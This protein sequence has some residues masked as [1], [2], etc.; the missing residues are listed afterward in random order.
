MVTKRPRP[1]SDGGVAD[2]ILGAAVL[3]VALRHALKAEPPPGSGV[4]A[5]ERPALVGS[6]PPAEPD[7]KIA[8]LRWRLD[9]AQRANPKLGFP[10]AVMKKFREDKA[11]YL[12]ALVAY[13]GFF[14]LFPLMVAFTS[15]LGFIVTDPAEQQ[16]FANAAADQIPVVGETIRANAG[17]L[18]GSVLGIVI[19]IVV[20]L[21]AGLRI[22]DAMQNALNQVWELPAIERPKLVKRRLRG[23]AMLGVIGGGLLGSIAASNVARVID[24]IPGTGRFAI[25]GAS[26][27]VSILMYL[28]AFQLLT[29]ERLEWRHL[30]PGAIFSGIA[31]WAL[32][33]FGA[34]YVVRQQE[35]AGRTYGQYASIIALMAFLYV[36]AQTSILGAEISA[37]RAH[38][39]WPRSL[40]KDNFTAADIDVFERLAG[41][42]RQNLAYEVKVHPARPP[43]SADPAPNDTVNDHASGE[44]GRHDQGGQDERGSAAVAPGSPSL[45]TAPGSHPAR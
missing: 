40:T 32:Q 10:L 44:H 27:L 7:G 9:L 35:A 31:W 23:L 4:D 30:W 36:A 38:R 20:A 14:S 2:Q 45:D 41:S 18:K 29:D 37:V 28:L 16:R 12:A 15:V 17:E 19:G 39:L 33:T 24:V 26:A 5:P 42:T 11:G 25:W 21:W 1:S 34:V 6:G 3:V 43:A 8:R 22:V 13:F